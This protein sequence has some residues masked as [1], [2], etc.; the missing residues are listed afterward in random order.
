MLRLVGRQVLRAGAEYRRLSLRVDQVRNSN[1]DF[2]PEFTQGPNPNAAA[3][4]DAFASF[5]LGV[6]D[7]GGFEIATPNDFFT[8][9]LGAFVQDD[10]RVGDNLTLNLGLRYELE[11]GLQE[12]NDAFTVGFDVDRPFPV[13]VPGLDLKGG[14]MY[15]C[16]DGYPTR[17]G[18]GGT[19]RQSSSRAT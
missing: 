8:N 19:S 12:A 5:L 15:A 7:G 2:T 17:Q 1:F 3:N 11:Q 4:G 6:P 18:R 14:L 9:Y 10:L 13:P 16:V